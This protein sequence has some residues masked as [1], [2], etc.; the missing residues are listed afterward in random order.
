MFT[1][2][3]IGSLLLMSTGCSQ[4]KGNNGTTG[5][6]LGGVTGALAANHLGKGSGRVAATMLGAFIGTVVGSEIGEYMDELDQKNAEHAFNEA[7]H[8]PIGKVIEWRNPQ[9]G[10]Y[11]HVK[12]LREGQAS[13]GEYCREFQSQVTI[14]G[15]IKDAYGT[16]CQ[17]PDGS[18]E[19]S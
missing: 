2:L 5:A 17:R 19:I 12:S 9:S 7:T 14:G 1:A 15:K 10:H 3:L 11:G 8:A 18:W 6:L 13:S 16:A 4:T